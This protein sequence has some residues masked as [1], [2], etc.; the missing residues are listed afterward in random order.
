PNAAGNLVATTFP[1]CN[2]APLNA[3]RVFSIQKPEE[4]KYIGYMDVYDDGGTQ[5][6]NGLIL[7]LQKR[8]SRGLSTGVNYTWSH[9]IGDFTQGGGVPNVGS[10]FLDPNDR[11]RDRGNCAA[12]RRHLLTWTGGYELP[13]WNNNLARAIFSDWRVAG[14][15]RFTTG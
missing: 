15:Y 14:L 3:R 12:D 4:G 10:G 1:V 7:S 5:S 2:N 6:Y 11:R 8:L 13:R 9:C